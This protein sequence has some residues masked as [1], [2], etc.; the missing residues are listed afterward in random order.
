MKKIN[1][2]EFVLITSFYYTTALEVLKLNT[3]KLTI[4]NVIPENTL[5][6]E[7]NNKM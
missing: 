2:L 3:Q 4:K 5:A 6:E 7:L 1:R